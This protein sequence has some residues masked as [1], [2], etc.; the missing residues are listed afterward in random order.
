MIQCLSPQPGRFDKDAQIIHHLVLPAEILEA[1]WT[2]GVLKVTFTPGQRMLVAY[3][4]I[5]FFHSLV[6]FA[7]KITNLFS[8]SY[9][10]GKHFGR[11]PVRKRKL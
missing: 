10:A 4:E 6:Y 8:Y 3:V 1:Q 2:Q 9:H 7:C 5:L 11:F